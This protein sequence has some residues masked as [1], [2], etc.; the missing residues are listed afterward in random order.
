MSLQN[1]KHFEHSNISTKEIANLAGLFIEKYCESETSVNP[2]RIADK[3][4][5]DTQY[6]EEKELLHDININ[7]LLNDS[8][9]GSI[10]VN[11]NHEAS[12]K[13]NKNLT[14]NQERKTIAHEL[15]HYVLH[16]QMGNISGYASYIPNIKD[17][18]VEEQANIFM[19]FLLLPT[20]R[21]AKEE[22][23]NPFEISMKYD[24]SFDLVQDRISFFQTNQY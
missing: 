17:K 12:F 14:Y 7:D 3:L 16:S 20:S 21:I 2:K 22:S 19:M 24:V 10:V 18:K 11:D 13:I 4:N 9:Y 5:I 23:L 1:L 8:Q 6:L 15:G